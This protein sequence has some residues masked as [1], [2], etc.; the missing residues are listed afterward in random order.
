L[1][2]FGAQGV[3]ESGLS[4][5]PQPPDSFLAY[6]SRALERIEMKAHCIVGHGQVIG[7]IINGPG[8][9]PQQG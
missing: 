1:L 2:T 5:F 4:D 7:E 6:G 8:F 3:K 9:L